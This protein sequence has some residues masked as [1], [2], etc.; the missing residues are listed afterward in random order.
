MTLPPAPQAVTKCKTA[1]VK[2]FMVTGDHPITAEAIAKQVR[3]SFRG[4]PGKPG[5]V[6]PNCPPHSRTN[7]HHNLTP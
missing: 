3:P 5:R 4:C 1:S 2:V 7:H 6:G